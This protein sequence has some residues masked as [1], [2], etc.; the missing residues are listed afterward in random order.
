MY[1]RALDEGLYPSAKKMS[2]ALGVDLGNV[3]RYLALARLP[4]DV[5]AAFG[6]PL[7]LQ[8]R[9]AKNLTDSMQKNPDL[10][11]SRARGLFGTTPR[12][13]A[14]E[15]LK[16]LTSEEGVVPNNPPPKA[17]VLVKGKGGQTGEIAYNPKKRSVSI[18]LNGIDEKR[19]TEI[20]ETIKALLS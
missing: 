8:Q 13:A 6:S 7:D 10:V 12:P 1:A 18:S 4:A 17:P 15:V 14:A 5:L 20:E 2:E 19:L 3:G 16:I 9:W 11:L